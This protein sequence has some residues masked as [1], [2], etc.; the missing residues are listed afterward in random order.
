MNKKIFM[1]LVFIFLS[2]LPAVPA[3]AAPIAGNIKLDHFGYR[4]ADQKIAYFTANPGPSVG[5]YD[6]NTNSLV[7]TSTNIT[8]K[9]TDTGTPLISGDTLWWVDFSGFTAPGQYY[10]L[11]ASLNEQ[12]YDFQI[13]DCVYQAATTATLKALYYQRCGTPKPAAYAGANWADASAC[14]TGDA[15]C[16]PAP[17]CTFPATYGTLDLSG[18]WHDAGDYNKYIGSTPAGACD[19]W[20][21]DGGGAIHYILTAYEWNPGLFPDSQTNIPESG[22]GI[23]D[24][25]DECKWELDWYLKMQMT[26]KH[27][28]SV[29]H[30]TVYTTGS[31]PSTDPTVRYYYPPNPTGEASFVAVLS[32]AARVMSAVPALNSYA[33]TLKSAAEATWNT[34][35]ASW[36]ASDQKFWAAAEIFRME[37]ALGGSAAII[38]AAKA[39]VEGYKTWNGWWM[40]ENQYQ[41]N[42]GMLA[43]MQS[44]G[45]TAAVVNN[46]KTDWGNLA[47]DIFNQSGL[48][49]SGMH[50]Y[51]YFWGANEVKMNYA[52][53]LIW[54]AKLGA[55]GTHTA[56]QCLAH[57][58]DFLHYMDGSNPVNMVFMTNAAALGASH[59]VWRIYHSWF[60]NYNVAF[61][62]NNF[63]GKPA[64]VVDPLYPYYTGPDNYGISD[65]GPSV[66]GPPPGIVPDGPCSEYFSDGGKAIPPLLAGGAAPPYEKGYRDWNYSDPTGGQ[67]V[68]W[69]VNETGIYYISSYMMVASAFASA[70]SA[71]TATPTVTGTPPTATPTG[72]E[73]ETATV[74]ETRTVTSTRTVT[75][76][77]TI[78]KTVTQTCTVTPYL[79]PTITMT[80]VPNLSGTLQ[81]NDVKVWPNAYNPVVGDLNIGY[82]LTQPVDGIDLKLYTLSF[83]LIRQAKLSDGDTAG[84]KIKAL[85]MSDL[86]TLANG[87]YYIVLAG[88]QQDKNAVSHTELLIII[89]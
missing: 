12:S 56:A 78:T 60:G 55:T 57:A 85:N 88:K 67:T 69:I 23:S 84:A 68:P 52:Q 14:H 9:G 61:S 25:L 77:W 28:L 39:I 4:T 82:T 41:I 58:E 11:S 80:P 89:R 35:S 50:T 74:T 29:V 5:V 43:Y 65:S 44:A 75:A 27:V 34:F 16:Q 79:S 71:A 15:A 13:S 20:G 31:P 30:Q 59:G 40:N 87:L 72:S 32:H 45:A 42:W 49:N 63:M 53:E 81:I 76:T 18:G 21:G 36:A 47:N 51:D 86:N 2:V 48:Y 24:L 17:G 62:F 10:L 7:Y 66:Y 26:D 64:A 33:M 38:S 46:M 1:L 54:A 70:C 73:T 22:N 3:P 19:N 8:S 6:A 37:N 83:R